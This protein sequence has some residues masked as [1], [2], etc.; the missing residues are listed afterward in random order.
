MSVPLEIVLTCPPPPRGDNVD[1]RAHL[2]RWLRACERRG[3]AGVLLHG[4]HRLPEPWVL[5][6]LILEAGSTVTPVITLRPSSLHPYHAAR[7]LAALA[8]LYGRVPALVLAAG[9]ARSELAALAHDAPH[10]QRYRRLLEYGRVLRTCL[11]ATRPIVLEGEFYALRHARPPAPALAGTGAPRL[12]VSGSS[13]AGRRAA[14]ALAAQR[15]VPA[16]PDQPAAEGVRVGV[17]ARPCSQLAWQAA[18]E[19]FGRDAARRLEHRL[20]L[21]WSDSHWQHHLL[22]AAMAEAQ[23]P[24]AEEALWLEPFHS[25]QAAC[26]YVVGDTRTVARYLR[27]FLERGARTLFL[28]TPADETE[29]DHALAAVERAWKR[30]RSP[31]TLTAQAACSAGADRR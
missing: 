6:Q 5:A 18:H 2:R 23:V 30:Y 21:A 12:F 15:V 3:V 20:E 11:T 8:D 22:A 10:E 28:D 14:A 7:K 4:G 16:L 31:L 29:L 19:R 26:P 1:A 17:V 25:G 24:E 9:D 13:T 27:A